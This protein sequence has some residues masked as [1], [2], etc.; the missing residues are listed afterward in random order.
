ML[1]NNEQVNDEYSVLCIQHLNDNKL[2]VNFEHFRQK[3]YW[4]DNKHAPKRNGQLKRKGR[5][6]DG[7]RRPFVFVLCHMQ[8]K[9]TPLP[10]SLSDTHIQHRLALVFSSFPCALFAKHKVDRNNYRLSADDF[11]L[12]LHLA[13]PVTQ[14]IIIN[15]LLLLL[16]LLLSVKSFSFQSYRIS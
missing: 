12:V 8:T 14:N 1:L 4:N 7:W 6:D 15:S 2:P 5:C 3:C 11:Y 16:L 9:S 13:S 10:F